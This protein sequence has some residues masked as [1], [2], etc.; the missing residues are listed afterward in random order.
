MR[1]FFPN[2]TRPKKAAKHIAQRFKMPLSQAQ[3]GIACAAGYRDWHELE[4]GV[5]ATLPSPLDQH[6]TL[7]EFIARHAQLT[8]TLAAELGVPDG[9]AQSALAKA[10]LSG[11]RTPDLAEQIAVRLACFRATSLPV[12]GARMPGAV[13]KIKS[14][15]RNGELV[16][17]RSFGAPTHA[18]THK[19]SVLIADFEYVSPRTPLPLFLPMRLYLPYGVW[20]EEDGAQVLFSRDYKPLWRVG[21][22]GVVERLEPWLWIRHKAQAYLWDEVKTPWHD[23]RLKA[24]LEQRLANLGIHELPILADALPLLVHAPAERGLRISDAADLLKEARGPAIPLAA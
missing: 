23:R 19:G 12:A 20:T 2:T 4:R 9:D 15:G 21:V 1:L 11:E 14:A 7:D 24:A 13:G 5:D 6:Q 3:R 18:I 10:R 22:D 16:I 8:G 17:L